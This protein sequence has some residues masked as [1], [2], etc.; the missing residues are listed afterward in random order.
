VERKPRNFHEIH[1]LSDADEERMK[2]IDLDPQYRTL[3]G[4]G[5][6]LLFDCPKGGHRVAIPTNG[7]PL[8][9]GAR[10]TITNGDDFAKLSIH[11]SIDEGPEC[12]HGWVQ[13]GEVT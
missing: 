9:N 11:P 4:I 2:L 10:W 12:W 8:E 6:C 13:N 7:K 5:E 1:I 3:G